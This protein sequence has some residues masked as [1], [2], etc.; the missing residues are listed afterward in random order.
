M[1]ILFVC[2]QNKWRSPTAERVFAVDYGVNT[3]SAGTSRNAKHVIS[4]K[5]VSWAD[6]IFV[7]EYHHKKAIQE[8]FRR[9]L[10]S[11]K[12]IVLEIPDD[13]QYMDEDLITLLKEAVP[14][15]LSP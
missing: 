1:N 4:S 11:K 3:R 15:Y 8:K 7:M 6:L 14:I 5:D 13:Y 12:I 9:D 10:T 2:S